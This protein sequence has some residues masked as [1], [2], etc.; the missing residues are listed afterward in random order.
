MKNGKAKSNLNQRKPTFLFP[1]DKIRFS[2]FTTFLLSVACLQPV[3]VS[4][5]VN[6]KFKAVCIEL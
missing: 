5:L 4:N 2:F 3:V 1:S 6:V